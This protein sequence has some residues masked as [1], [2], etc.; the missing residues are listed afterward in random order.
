MNRRKLLADLRAIDDV[1]VET[2][3]KI[4]PHTS[5][6]IGGPASVW[7]EP[8]SERAVGQVLEVVHAHG[9]QLFVLGGG[10]NVRLGWWLAGDCTAYR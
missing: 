3:H 1:S 8:S 4:A 5:Y 7:V 9:E 10:S 6:R 2:R